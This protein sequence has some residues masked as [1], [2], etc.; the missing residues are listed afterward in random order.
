MGEAGSIDSN[1]LMFKITPQND[2]AAMLTKS[3]ISQ[4]ELKSNA[5]MFKLSPQKGREEN[6]RDGGGGYWWMNKTKHKHVTEI[7]CGVFYYSSLSYSMYLGIMHY[8]SLYDTDML[9]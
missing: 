3:R 2:K 8:Q 7:V 5:Q 4:F 6:T 9:L 1:F